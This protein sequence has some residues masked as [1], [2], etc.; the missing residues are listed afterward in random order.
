MKWKHRRKAHSIVNYVSVPDIVKS[1]NVNLIVQQCRQVTYATRNE[2]RDIS[3]WGSSLNEMLNF[4]KQR[5]LNACS[6][7]GSHS[8]RCSL[9]RALCQCNICRN[10]FHSRA[11]GYNNTTAVHLTLYA[12]FSMKK[13]R[14]NHKIFYSK[15]C[16]LLAN[17]LFP[18]IWQFMD[19][20]APCYTV[21]IIFWQTL[22]LEWYYFATET[23]KQNLFA[24]WL[25]CWRKKRN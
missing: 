7:R 1:I 2:G 17:T 20:S 18:P 25:Y 21:D 24:H 19:N 5:K 6:V 15:C 4:F 8:L 14:K 12:D 3:I 10:S 9:I 23:G 11:Y 13:Q 22:T 16:L